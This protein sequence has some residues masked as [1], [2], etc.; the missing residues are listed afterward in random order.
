MEA[1]VDY[2]GFR[3]AGW[4][5]LVLPGAG[6][7]LC[8]AI[9]S[10]LMVGLLVA[11]GANLALAA[12][13]LF[14][15]DFSRTVQAVIIGLAVGSY[16]GAQLR[17]SQTQRQIRAQA[18][19][20]ARRRTLRRTSELLAN[21]EPAA[22]LE[23]LRPLADRAHDDLLV[24]YRMAQT[25]TV[26]GD[27]LAARVAWQRVRQLDRHGI[28]RDQVRENERALDAVAQEL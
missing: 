6:L 11:A 24:A 10:G 12:L 19:G 7:V 27:V 26:A 8:G 13:L 18:A 21:G 15:D 23:A 17:L 2:P 1:T 14:P 20:E 28:Y 5:N 9:A 25:L 22:A 4:V 16:F 3:W